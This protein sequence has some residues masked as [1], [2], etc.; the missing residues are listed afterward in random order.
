MQ[1]DN[2]LKIDMDYGS[3]RSRYLN[4]KFLPLIIISILILIVQMS[5][6]ASF[7]N[8]LNET[9]EYLTVIST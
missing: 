7:L 5:F 3:R 9:I 2:V 4:G 6:T 1:R 8:G